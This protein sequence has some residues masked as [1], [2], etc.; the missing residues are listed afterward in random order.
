MKI[1]E[2]VSKEHVH[3]NDSNSNR[4]QLQ[5]FLE[6][7]RTNYLSKEITLGDDD[8]AFSKSKAYSFESRVL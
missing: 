3:V 2:S 6:K 8:D 4:D 5:H 1:V 7:I